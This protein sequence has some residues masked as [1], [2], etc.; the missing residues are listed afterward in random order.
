MGSFR[1]A[2]RVLGPS[3]TV[4]GAV[5]EQVGP[6]QAHLLLHSPQHGRCPAGVQVGQQLEGDEPLTGGDE[7]EVAAAARQAVGGESQRGEVTCPCGCPQLGE[8]VIDLAHE[9]GHSP[10]A[11]DVRK[12]S[13]QSNTGRW[14]TYALRS[15]HLPWGGPPGRRPPCG[16]VPV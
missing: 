12:D 3:T 8:T 11:L 6:P 9:V 5:V 14:D 4:G 2:A 7:A 13:S 15:F 10:C 1:G 16:S